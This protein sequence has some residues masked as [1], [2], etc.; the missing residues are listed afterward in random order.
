MH[1]HSFS[2]ETS[3]TTPHMNCNES[4]GKG[5]CNRKE[6]WVK[7]KQLLA[8]NST[9][10]THQNAGAPLT[11]WRTVQ[12]QHKFTPCHTEWDGSSQLLHIS[13]GV[14]KAW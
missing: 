3:V 13:D 6:M 7:E 14:M 1:L 8:N 12:E 4:V 10:M 2:K 5:P 11:V 9:S